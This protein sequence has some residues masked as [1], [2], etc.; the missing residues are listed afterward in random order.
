M[1]KSTKII[2]VVSLVLVIV[3]VAYF[4]MQGTKAI[5][6][7]GSGSGS[8]GSAATSE[9]EGKYVFT[10]GMWANYDCANLKSDMTTY[11]TLGCGT[12]YVR[13]GKRVGWDSTG[14]SGDK[15]VS[16]NV[17]EVRINIPEDKL[18]AIP[19]A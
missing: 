6:G 14:I 2:I 1:K 7:S 12:W 19:L 10:E 17:F 9:Y 18:Q 4:M 5:A 16:G 3:V 15:A 11:N 13:D 8:G